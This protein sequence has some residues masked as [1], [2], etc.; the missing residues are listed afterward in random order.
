MAIEMSDRQRRWID[1]L[2]VLATIAVGFIV[3]G[4]VG[5]LFFS[6]GDIILIFFLAWLLA[7]ILSPVVGW[8]TRL[9]PVLPRAGAVIV[10]YA[11]LL[12]GLVVLT[13]VVAGALSSSI[14]DFV[15]SVPSLQGRLPEV[16]APWQRR[17]DELGLGQVDLAAQAQIFL[18]NLN[19]YAEDLAG[20]LQQVAVASLGALGSLVLILILSLYIGID[21][22]RIVSFLFRI[23]PPGF[24]DQARLLE[25]SVAKSFG[26]FLRGQALMGVV[27]ATVAILTSAVL[28][29]PYLPVTSALAGMLMAIPF[30]GPFVAWAPPVL[31]A[32][33]LVPNATLPAVIAMG[34]GWFIVMNVLQPRLMEETVGIH[35][36]VVLGSVLVGSKIAG[37]AG[38]IFGIPIAAIL[39]AFFFYY[40]GQTRDAGPVAARAA[41]RIE[42]REGRPI[43]VPR[44]PDPDADAD[45]A[46]ATRPAGAAGSPPAR[47]SRPAGP[48]RPAVARPA[49]P[50]NPSDVGT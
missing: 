23:V 8:L 33:F 13:V 37:V 31:V 19:Q 25:T 32:I 29:L 27:Y 45:L 38:A 48:A 6:F 10:V 1:A 5:D 3:V 2:L 22:D 50:A 24:K 20:P 47:A 12:G 41:R 28:N 34:V 4:F 36:I 44:E 11:L 21:R 16:L 35:P 17:L 39:S 18:A 46:D 43:R 15:A 40:L 7:F 42:A 9:V 14:T 30:F 26:G 49:H